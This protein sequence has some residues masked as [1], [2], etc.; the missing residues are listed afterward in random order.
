MKKQAE[1]RDD[2]IVTIIPKKSPDGNA[3]GDFILL[4]IRLTLHL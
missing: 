4:D 2:N 1:V 3:P